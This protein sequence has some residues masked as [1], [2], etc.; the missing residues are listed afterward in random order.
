MGVDKAELRVDG[1]R[2]AVRVAR[3]LQAV[4]GLTIVASGDGR[5]LSWLGL[6]QVVDIEQGEGPLAGLIAGLEAAPTRY[7]AVLAVDMPN[8][9]APV[10][11]L[12]AQAVSGHDAAVPR[13]GD[14]L[15]PLHAVYATAAAPLLRTWFEG[16]VRSVRQALGALDLVVVAPTEWSAAD[17]SG[18]F[19]RNL[20]RPDDLLLS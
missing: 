4:A 6:P 18:A 10:L 1:E 14:G 15:Q 5:R 17:P 7:V 2:L 16:G 11:R 19:A 9:S 13:T 12:L 8:A 3:V 20:N